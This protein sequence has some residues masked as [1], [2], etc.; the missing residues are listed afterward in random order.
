MGMG[1]IGAIG[2]AGQGLVNEGA[3]LAKEDA[4]NAEMGRKKDYQTWLLQTQEEYAVRTENR[5]WK[6]EQERAPAKRDMAVEDEKAKARG[7]SAVAAE[8]VDTDVGVKQKLT[9]AGVST[10]DKA[11][12]K[13]T[14][15][16]YGEKGDALDGKADPLDLAELKGVQARAGKLEDAITKAK[17][18]GSWS[19]TPEQK[20][21]QAQL[22]ALQLRERTILQKGRGGDTAMADPLG[23]RKTATAKPGGM[24]GPTNPSAPAGRAAS[25]F[26]ST[27]EEM[28]MTK[29]YTDLFNK[30][31]SELAEAKT[32]EE[33]SR[34]T[35]ALADIRREAAAQNVPLPG[36]A[37]PAAPTGAAAAAPKPA[38]APRAAAAPMDPTEALGQ[39]LDAS[40]AAYK[41]LTE[42]SKR[43]GLA[44][45]G[46]ARDDYAATVSS[47]RDKIR[48]QERRYAD[49]VG[50]Q[51]AAF[52]TARP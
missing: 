8:T 50:N 10:D 18:E 15:K 30:V 51:G 42:P 24:I 11:V 40:R 3:F 6:N 5:A 31:S 44:A 52:A 17:A 49:A 36:G 33:R 21:L 25:K 41:A 26:A 14:A 2:G 34:A 12:K 47:L 29:T 27:P 32:P 37:A 22:A 43:P 39:E 4:A 28:D 9:D 16:L 48:Q 19:G 38:P 45:G 20:Q 46:K 13:A 23:V 7:K 35:T 1:M